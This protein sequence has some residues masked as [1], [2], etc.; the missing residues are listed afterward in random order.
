ML[1]YELEAVV[2]VVSAVFESGVVARV[3]DLCPVALGC[4]HRQR[5]ES[6]TIMR[7]YNA[8]IARGKLLVVEAH[9]LQ[10]RRLRGSFEG[11][12]ALRYHRLDVALLLVEDLLLL[13]HLPVDLL[14]RLHYTPCHAAAEDA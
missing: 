13:A 4:A 5:P 9:A 3:H 14:T 8:I 7:E 6:S 1:R 2:N 11:F 12:T 10:V